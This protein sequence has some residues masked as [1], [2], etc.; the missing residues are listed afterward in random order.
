M[1]FFNVYQSYYRQISGQQPPTNLQRSAQDRQQKAEEHRQFRERLIAA[2]NSAPN[3][4]EVNQ[5][6]ANLY[7]L[8]A[9]QQNG[10]FS[11]A[12]LVSLQ[13]QQLASQLKNPIMGTPQKN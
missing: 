13:Q 3:A 5:V 9:L 6:P 7:Q 10:Q 12:Q 1:L 2:A 4:S 8:N 11:A